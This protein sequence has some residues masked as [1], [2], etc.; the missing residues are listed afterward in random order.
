MAAFPQGPLV[1]IATDLGLQRSIKKEQQF[2]AV[3]HTVQSHFHFTKKETAYLWISYYSNGKFDNNL[4]ANAKSPAT[5]P[6]EIAYKNSAEMRFKHFSLGWKHYFKG[7]Y[8]MEEGWALYGYAGFGMMLGKV[9]NKHPDAID[10]SLYQLPVLSGTANFK[11]L[12]WDLGLGWETLIGGSAYFYNELR[13]W[14]PASDY[15]ST[16]L[17]VNR[18]APLVASLNFGIRILFD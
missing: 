8:D 11:R 2:W 12:T 3:G 15:P 4:S 16:H 7:T 18:K 17:F 5:S 6:Q 1:S 10:T 9:I 13:V 14:V